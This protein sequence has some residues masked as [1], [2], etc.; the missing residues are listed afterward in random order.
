MLELFTKLA[1]Y[2]VYDLAGMEKGS[3]LAGSIHF[4]IEDT[5][6][7]Y[8]LLVIMIYT[9]AWLRASLKIE[10]VRDYL[11]GKNR[12]IG[13]FSGS[14]FGAVTPF[15]SCSSIP[16]FFGF[17]QARIPLGITMSFL[18]TSPIVNEVAVVLLGSLLGVKFMVIY[19][20][21]GI[22]SGVVGGIFLDAIKAERF[23]TPLVE[24]IKGNTAA[25]SSSEN[26]KMT[27]ADRHKFAKEELFSIFSRVWKWVLIGVGLGA[28]LHGVV[29]ES[30]VVENLGKGQWWTVPAAVFIGI[31]LYSNATGIIPVA[32]SLLA[33][34]LPV[35]TTLAFM[36][37]TVAASF[38]EFMLLKQVMK[39]ELLF[40][41]FGMLLVL[42]TFTGWILNYIF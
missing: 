11:A 24:N 22:L 9:I 6:K 25:Q 10:R 20:L 32:E 28:V 12:W 37:S 29:P 39:K 36:M 16:L 21:V 1:D 34:G 17:T 41:F 35:G 31:P 42:F 2:L 27:F 4:F 33:K 13:Y 30:F 5:T 3:H 8:F 26:E 19:V 7:I 23:L 15:C 14:V 40:I 38:P 18:I